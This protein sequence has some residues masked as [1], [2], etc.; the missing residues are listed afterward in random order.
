[1][2]KHRP[3]NDYPYFNHLLRYQKIYL[4]GLLMLLSALSLFSNYLQ[5]KPLLMGGE[6]YF[7][8]SSG[9]PDPSYQPLTLFF[10]VIPDQLAYLFPPLL[11]VGIIL[12]FYSLAQKIN[13][14]E[15]KAFLI[16]LFYILTPT[17][18]FTSLA[19]SSYSLFLLLTLCGANVL[20]L[21]TKKKYFALLPFLLASWIDTFSA[22]LLLGGLA[23]YF[24]PVKKSKERFPI[25]LLVGIAAVLVLNAAVLKSPF[26][27]GPF[28]VQ[29]KTADLI[30]DLGSFSGVGIF[31]ILL[32]IIGLISS[33]QKKNVPLLLPALAVFII[34]YL[35]N[36][37]TVFFLS[38]LIVILAA[39]G[40][41][42]L[43]EQSWSLP[44][45]RNA[46]L[47]LLLL[48]I[49]FSAVAYLDRLSGY[50]PT[51]VDQ[52]ALEWIQRN[53]K[54]ETAVLSAPENSYY[55]AYF[56]QRKPV[57]SLHQDYQHDY[58]LS[59]DIFSAFYID[60]LFPL[61]EKNKVSIIYISGEMK[62][63]LPAQQEFLFLLQNERF[64]LLYFTEDAE[65]WSFEAKQ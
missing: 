29:H 27:L 28:T 64:K 41:V 12:L 22:L 57:F 14:P 43:V 37:H 54:E 7:Y 20:L 31:A 34:A 56:A 46:A 26:F 16:V 52:K 13:I 32:A 11:S 18:I 19:L 30:S 44:F 5:E 47:L 50:P 33:W 61:L 38:L 53:T 49:S 4:C 21:G 63:Q 6:S 39:A 3:Q 48:G 24:F 58:Q 36:T 45:L 1:M 42:D 59:R 10:R 62:R 65:V 35:F 55:I 9:Q 2:N 25:I 23:V 40:F 15:K 60:E 8:L 51:A 17:F